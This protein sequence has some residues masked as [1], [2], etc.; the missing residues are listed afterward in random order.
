MTKTE[1][2]DGFHTWITSQLDLRRR[3]A[4]FGLTDVE[5]AE[6]RNLAEAVAW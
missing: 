3:T 5:A 1:V 4:R 6:L 2:R